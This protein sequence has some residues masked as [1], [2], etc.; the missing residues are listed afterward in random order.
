M[1][2]LEQFCKKGR[3]VKGSCL[4]DVLGR[5]GLGFDILE[6]TKTIRVFSRTSFTN[7]PKVF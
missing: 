7:R 4:K 3:N 5:G 6:Y 2:G 1:N